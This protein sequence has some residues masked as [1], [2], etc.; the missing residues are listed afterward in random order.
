VRA[1]C[2]NDF[3]E[4]V[5]ISALDPAVHFRFAD[6]SGVDFKGCNLRGFDFTGARLHGCRFEGAK[7]AE[8]L[9]ENGTPT[10]AARFELA[11]LGAVSHDREP[12]SHDPAVMTPVADL[13]KAAD[14]PDFVRG[15]KKAKSSP[16]R[17]H[18]HPGAIFQDAPFAPEMVVVPAGEFWMGSPDG[19]G[20][21]QGDVTELARFEG[22]GRRHRVTIT[23]PF[24]V[25]RFAVTFEEWDAAQKHPEW[26]EYS[27]LEPRR[28]N[29]H[30]WGRG[31]RPVIDVSWDDAQAYC[32]WLKAVRGKPY[33][34]PSE[35]EWEYC[36]RADTETPFWWGVSTSTSQANYD[37]KHTYGADRGEG[38]G[39]MFVDSFEANPW[40]LH[41]VHG[42]VWEWCDDAWH[43]SYDGTPPDD[44]S[45]W[46]QGG[47]A[48]QRV[49]RGGCWINVPG[50]LRSANRDRYQP[51]V[52]GY[53]LGFR[54]ART[55]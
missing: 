46:Q 8:G 34:L 19:S 25:G 4:L 12:G 16:A 35:A 14:W 20:G 1:A 15:W 17:E 42:N 33:R 50:C 30:T 18:L 53:G 6:W 37:V 28:P 49:V 21:D 39:T 11:E 44:G 10:P 40:G 48:S 23:R 45:P 26:R 9:D 5:R 54:L 31:P 7:I 52:R 51:D 55:L 32:R 29:D 13:R 41:Q 36:C 22:E 38:Q 43:E 47:D 27:G 3:T 2:T 24:A